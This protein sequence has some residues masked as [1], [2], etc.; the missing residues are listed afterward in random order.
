M[1]DEDGKTLMKQWRVSALLIT[2]IQSISTPHGKELASTWRILV[3]LLATESPFLSDMS[4][5]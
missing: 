2:N 3:Y 5:F 4:D 1:P